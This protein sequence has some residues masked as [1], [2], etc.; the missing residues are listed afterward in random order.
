MGYTP[1]HRGRPSD[2]A[3]ATR[4]DRQASLYVRP[5]QSVPPHWDLDHD[6]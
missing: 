6:L 3:G 1:S 4:D 2:T 5:L